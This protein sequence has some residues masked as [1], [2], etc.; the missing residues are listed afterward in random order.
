MKNL[1]VIYTNVIGTIG[2][3][4]ANLVISAIIPTILLFIITRAFTKK[5]PFKLYGKLFQDFKNDTT[6]NKTIFWNNIKKIM[7]E[8]NERNKTTLNTDGEDNPLLLFFNKSLNI[9]ETNVPP[10]KPVE[11]ETSFYADIDS[12]Y[13]TGSQ[14][15]SL[16][17]HQQR[18]KQFH[19]ES[20]RKRIL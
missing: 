13:Q 17:D 16:Q 14:G 5:N 7:K 10:V 18:M 20:K 15:S 12:S 2:E 19:K 3:L 1:L 4:L 9:T 11:S 6:K 8:A